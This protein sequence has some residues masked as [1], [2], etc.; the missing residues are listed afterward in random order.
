LVALYGGRLEN[1]NVALTKEKDL[2]K[3]S[4]GK[5][6]WQRSYFLQC[7]IRLYPESTARDFK[8]SEA[9]KRTKIKTNAQ[10]GYCQKQ[11]LFINNSLLNLY[12]VKS[13]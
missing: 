2:L 9:V 12:V 6:I 8:R 1:L 11:F 7:Y 10:Y 5:Q 4:C 13:T 3:Q